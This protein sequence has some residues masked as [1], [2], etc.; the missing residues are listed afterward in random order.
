MTTHSSEIRI[1]VNLKQP[2]IHSR[3]FHSST[4]TQTNDNSRQNREIT[5][6]FIFSSII[7]GL[8]IGLFIQ[9][10]TVG[11]NWL[12]ISMFGE[13]AIVAASGRKLVFYSFTWLIVTSAMFMWMLKYLRDLVNLI[14]IYPVRSEHCSFISHVDEKNRVKDFTQ[15]SA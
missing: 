7:L 9:F 6:Y 11:A 14:E 12:I 10:S 3:K 13:E 1:I 15:L 4:Q 5:N 2:L 8:I